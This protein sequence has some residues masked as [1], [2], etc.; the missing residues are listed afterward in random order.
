MP[1]HTLWFHYLWGSLMG[2]GPEALA[3][4]VV[5]GLIAL[6]IIPPAR[7][8]IERFAKRH[9]AELHAKLD[10]SIALS[11]HIIDNHPS[12]PPFGSVPAVASPEAKPPKETP[13]SFDFAKLEGRFWHDLDEVKSDAEAVLH[14]K[15]V[16][17]CVAA[18]KE[19]LPVLPDGADVEGVLA[20]LDELASEAHRA[21]SDVT[22]DGS[23]SADSAP[24]GPAEAAVG[25]SPSETAAEAPAD[26]EHA[27]VVPDSVRVNEA[28]TIL[29]PQ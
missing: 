2:N 15:I 23:Q 17:A 26:T 1:W 28:G 18:A 14:S 7:R 4:T 20:K 24:P 10:H 22:A 12:I 8:A 6:A 9:A 27:A 21:V 5:Y 25:E 13:M 3:Q 29:P 16:D 11:K 19:V